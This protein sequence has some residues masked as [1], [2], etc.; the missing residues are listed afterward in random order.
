M[1]PVL[2]SWCSI[3][4]TSHFSPQTG[5]EATP[6]PPA[7]RPPTSPDHTS[8][9]ACHCAETPIHHHHHQPSTA[10]VSQL[11]RS[12][13]NVTCQ[14][15]SLW[16]GSSETMPSLCLHH[17]HRSAVCG[18]GRC[19]LLQRYTYIH[20]RWML[21]LIILNRS[22]WCILVSGCVFTQHGHQRWTWFPHQPVTS[23]V[24]VTCTDAQTHLGGRRGVHRGGGDGSGSLADG[25]AGELL[26]RVFGHHASTL[27][28]AQ[29][30]TH[31]EE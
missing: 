14:V 11:K 26:T 31:R 24:T 28:P 27:R 29:E 25:G 23:C 3:R 12:Q 19:S 7:R 10:G 18:Y 13:G 30:N 22:G 4:I 16:S 6:L 21:L 8:R 20:L 15:L 2:L 17:S 5:A 9:S 1:N